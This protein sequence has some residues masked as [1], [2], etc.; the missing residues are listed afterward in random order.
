MN[1]GCVN[2]FVEYFQKVDSKLQKLIYKMSIKGYFL[3]YKNI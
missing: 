2:I 3:N 1:R